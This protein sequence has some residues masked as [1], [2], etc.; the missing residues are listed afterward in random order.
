MGSIHVCARYCG[1]LSI[2]GAVFLF[3]IWVLLY[4][5]YRYIKIE[6]KSNE[7]DVTLFA[8][9]IYSFLAIGSF[10]VVY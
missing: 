10:S 1:I 2:A 9:L 4:M 6:S 5:D 7:K 8:A 3:G